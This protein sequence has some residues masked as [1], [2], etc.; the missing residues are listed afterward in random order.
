MLQPDKNFI[1]QSLLQHHF[2]F[3]MILFVPAVHANFD[4]DVHHLQ[5]GFFN[6]M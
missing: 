6:L 1:L 4:F 5:N 3:N 2:Y